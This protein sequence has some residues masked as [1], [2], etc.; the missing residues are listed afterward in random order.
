MA[1]GYVE[2]QAR[3]QEKLVIRKCFNWCISFPDVS[4]FRMFRGEII[5]IWNAFLQCLRLLACNL[6][7]DADQES[8]AFSNDSSCD[9]FIHPFLDMNLWENLPKKKSSIGCFILCSVLCFHAEL[10][11]TGSKV[12]PSHH[13]FIM[14]ISKLSVPSLCSSC[15][16]ILCS[17]FPKIICSAYDSIMSMYYLQKKFVQ[18]PNGKILTRVGK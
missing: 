9:L 10:N 17:N 15:R 6:W 2:E 18:T 11:Y 13:M 8:S 7:S 5:P 12:I 14:R 1:D 3:W 4:A 16:S